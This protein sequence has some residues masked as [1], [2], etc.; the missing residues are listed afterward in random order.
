MESNVRGFIE[1]K[2]QGWLDARANDDEIEEFMEIIKR[3][4]GE[5]KH[6]INHVNKLEIVIN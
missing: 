4:A 2:I 5:I 3:R 6:I 1:Q